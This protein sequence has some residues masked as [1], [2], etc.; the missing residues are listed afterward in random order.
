[1]ERLTDEEL[2]EIE[3]GDWLDG[4]YGMLYGI[5]VCLML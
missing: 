4:G 1:M 3:G 2:F 5:V